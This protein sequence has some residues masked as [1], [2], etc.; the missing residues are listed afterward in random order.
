MCLIRQDG[1]LS[2]EGMKFTQP[3][4]QEVKKIFTSEKMKNLSR[5]QIKILASMLQKT[6]AD[7]ALEAEIGK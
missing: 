7:Q 5:N 1:F 2:D 3:F 6:I 4:N